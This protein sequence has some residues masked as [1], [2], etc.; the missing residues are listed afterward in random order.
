[1][2]KSDVGMLEVGAAAVVIAPII[3]G[4]YLFSWLNEQ[5]GPSYTPPPRTKDEAIRKISDD[6]GIP[7]RK[8]REQVDRV[9]RMRL[10]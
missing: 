8:V 7:M 5:T 3:G 2:S 6:T 4:M 9:E 10:N 1:M